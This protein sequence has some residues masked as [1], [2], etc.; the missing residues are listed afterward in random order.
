MAE[1][2]DE[3]MHKVKDS[4]SF[5]VHGKIIRYSKNYRHHLFFNFGDS[6][7]YFIC[8]GYKTVLSNFS[9]FCY[10]RMKRVPTLKS[11]HPTKGYLAEGNLLSPNRKKFTE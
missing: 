10:W 11:D 6:L 4:K 2:Y 3:A 8:Y 9:L 7:I 1:T 5:Y